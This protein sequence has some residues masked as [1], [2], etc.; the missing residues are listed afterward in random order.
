MQ[1]R[2][3]CTRL[4]RPAADNE[5]DEFLQMIGTNSATSVSLDA[6]DDDATQSACAPFAAECQHSVD[7]SASELLRM[8]YI[9]YAIALIEEQERE[10]REQEESAAFE[11]GGEASVV[12]TAPQAV[13][14]DEAD[15]VVCLSPRSLR[16]KRLQYFEKNRRALTIEPLNESPS[17]SALRCGALTNTGMRCQLLVSRA[18][19][20]ERQGVPLCHVHRRSRNVLRKRSPAKQC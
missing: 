16:E 6:F 3:R 1:E 10:R 7:M 9:E 12:V 4:Q 8:Q 11:A 13:D 14:D 2:R 18:K 19:W 15:V 5:V 20:S 17:P